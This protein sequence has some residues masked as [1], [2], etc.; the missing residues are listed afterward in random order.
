MTLLVALLVGRVWQTWPVAP[1]DQL[2]G[3]TMTFTGIITAEPDRRDGRTL[4]TLSPKA[5]AP[6][7]GKVLLTVPSYPVFNY[8]DKVVATGKLARPENFETDSGKTFD[9]QNYLAKDNIYYQMSRPKV[10]LVSSGHGFW[11]LGQL[12]RMKN[13]FLDNLSRALPEPA[14]ALL[15]GITI[16]AKRGLDS[17]WQD[18]FRAVGLSHIIVLSGYN[19]TIVA[20][21]IGRAL[22]FAP[23]AVSLG[24]GAFGIILF[25]LMTGA[26]STAVRAALMA[27]IALLARGSGRLYQ[28]LSA[29]FI[30]AYLMVL[31]N[32]RI[33]FFD[34]SFQLS[35]LAT[36]GVILGPPLLKSKLKFIPERFGLREMTATTIAAQVLV[37]PWIVHKMGQLSLVALPANILV[38]TFVPL[39]MFLGFLAG[40]VGFVNYWLSLPFA[41]LSYIFLAYDLKVVALFAAV[42]FASVSFN[43]FPL[44][45]V[46]L[47]Y[48]AY[49][50]YYRRWLPGLRKI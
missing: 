29:L 33:L 6:I 46:L 20:E 12:Y 5:P 18:K 19:I 38:L 48:T 26:S 4:L 2:D 24:L 7:S 1:A 36:V 50:Y 14:A 28:N 39:T 15:G 35:F 37:L 8:G 34:I 9:Y 30:A 44:I 13:G 47:V 42:P 3:E 23:R 31:V 11:I 40:L 22:A 32:P 49:A 41:Y 17:E 45:L 43:Y 16:G 25:T 10:E 27:L 21:A